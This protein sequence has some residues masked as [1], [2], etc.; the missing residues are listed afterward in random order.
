MTNIYNTSTLSGCVASTSSYRDCLECVSNSPYIDECSDAIKK[1]RCYTYYNP[2]G[3]SPFCRKVTANCDIITANTPE[4]RCF[5]KRGRD[6]AYSSSSMSNCAETTSNYRECLRCVSNSPYIDE[7]TD[8][9]KKTRCFEQFN[10][11]GNSPFCSKVR[12]NCSIINS[13]T[14]EA[15]CFD[16]INN[17]VE[18]FEDGKVIGTTTTSNCTSCTERRRRLEQLSGANSDLQSTSTFRSTRSSEFQHTSRLRN[19]SQNLGKTYTLDQSLVDPGNT[20][21]PYNS[22]SVEYQSQSD[23]Q[24]YVNI[25]LTETLISE[26]YGITAGAFVGIGDIPACSEKN[27][28]ELPDDVGCGCAHDPLPELYAYPPGD[29]AGSRSYPWTYPYLFSPPLFRENCSN[30]DMNLG[31]YKA[32]EKMPKFPTWYRPNDSTIRV[33]YVVMDATKLDSRK[34]SVSARIE[35][36]EKHI[37]FSGCY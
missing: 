29:P 14:P 3:N 36:A 12:A 34:K 23:Y 22:F 17:T 13:N 11:G 21:L 10:P 28:G 2:E 19:I 24:E 37:T 30:L 31:C 8:A 6:V 16:G 15:K 4:S 26:N 7:C 1:T 35:I 33:V 9:I 18:Y 5:E 20:T 27:S 32:I 25:N